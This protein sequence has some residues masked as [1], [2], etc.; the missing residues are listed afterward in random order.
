MAEKEYSTYVNRRIGGLEIELLK[1]T[2]VNQV[3]RRI[4]GLENAD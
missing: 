3:N 4:G 2:D 1:D